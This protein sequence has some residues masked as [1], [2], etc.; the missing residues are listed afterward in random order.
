MKDAAHLSNQSWGILLGAAEVLSAVD[1][2]RILKLYPR[3]HRP[4]K[5][6][7]SLH[8]LLF[9]CFVIVVIMILRMNHHEKEFLRV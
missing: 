4:S 6:L 9:V 7:H 8:S 1:Y 3:L 5:S 2:M